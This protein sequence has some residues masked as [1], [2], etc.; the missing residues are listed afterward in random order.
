[1]TKV[2]MHEAKTRLSKLVELALKGEEVVIA[3]NGKPTAKIVPYDTDESEDWFGMDAGKGW[4]G[5][6]FN[7]LDPE[8]LAA[9]YGE[10]EETDTD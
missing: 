3:K 6:D 10:D 9:I 7:E 2:N 5:E 1:M 8:L 4:I